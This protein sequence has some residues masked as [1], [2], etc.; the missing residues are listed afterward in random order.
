MVLRW[1][2]L[3]WSCVVA[4]AQTSPLEAALVFPG[5]LSGCSVQRPVQLAWGLRS[6]LVPGG[7]GGLLAS[8]GWWPPHERA[9][10]G[11]LCE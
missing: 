4:L 8:L 5:A 9:Y 10:K 2:S 3:S 1:V 11:V 6:W 7:C